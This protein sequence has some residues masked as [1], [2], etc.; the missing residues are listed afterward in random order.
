MGVADILSGKKICKLYSLSS[1]SHAQFFLDDKSF[2]IQ[3][4]VHYILRLAGCWGHHVIFSF[5]IMHLHDTLDN[6]TETGDIDLAYVDHNK[7]YSFISNFV[8]L[9]NSPFSYNLVNG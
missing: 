9:I 7:N 3:Y 8:T 4:T 2:Y 6:L 1:H 5:G